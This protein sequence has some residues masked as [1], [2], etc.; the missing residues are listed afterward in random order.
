MGPAKA[1]DNRDRKVAAT[2]ARKA[3]AIARK[4]IADSRAG[5]LMLIEYLR[6][7]RTVHWLMYVVGN[8][9]AVSPVQTV[10][11]AIVQFGEILLGV[12]N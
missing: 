8:D 3:T 5:A 1:N 6:V 12:G 9:D 10:L 7:V 4:G 2:A 11:T